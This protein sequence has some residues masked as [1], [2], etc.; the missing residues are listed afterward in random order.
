MSYL[1]KPFRRVKNPPNSVITH[2]LKL[3]TPNISQGVYVPPA[4][5]PSLSGTFLSS[6][7]DFLERG[8]WLKYTIYTSEVP[9]FS[10]L[11]IIICIQLK[12]HM[13]IKMLIDFKIPKSY[14]AK[15][16]CFYYIDGILISFWWWR[17]QGEGLAQQCLSH[18]LLCGRW[19]PVFFSRARGLQVELMAES[20]TQEQDS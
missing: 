3:K 6:A 11:D 14:W 9:I 2:L 13:L 8:E 1:Y 5:P 19:P 20:W 15:M 16:T 4:P 12:Y 10:I 18:P 17:S 7:Y